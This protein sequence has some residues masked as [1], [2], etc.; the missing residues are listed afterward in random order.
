MASKKQQGE[1]KP[2]SIV[3]AKYWV[4]VL[5]PENMVD[6]WERDIGDIV[7]LPYAYCVHDADHNI[8]GEE[9]KTHV[10]L[11]LVWPNTTT[12]NHALKVF[13]LLGEKACNTCEA[14]VNIRHKYDYLIHDTDA[15]R[16]AGKYQYPPEARI[17]GNGFD[18]GAYEQV[19]AAEKQ[20]RLKEL[21]G[22]IMANGY[23]T[24]N[25]FTSAA[26]AQYPANYWEII[27]GYNGTL[28]RYCRGNYL[29]WKQQQEAENAP[30]TTRQSGKNQHESGQK[31][32]GNNCPECESSDLQKWGKTA[33]DQQRW[34]CKECGKTFV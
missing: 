3:S 21:I 31:Q 27:V 18:I 2:P 5:Y 28:E 19:S 16:A 4:S 32:H 25:D 34:R 17:E 8:D 20:E 9:R 33:S 1:V 10:H 29:K 26:I 13:K 30:K 15:A 24:I 7:Q 23:M 22:F 12:Y 11:I 14:I 6:N